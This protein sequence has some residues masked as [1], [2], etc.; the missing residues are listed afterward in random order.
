LPV[1][2][3]SWQVDPFWHNASQSRWWTHQ[4]WN[5]SRSRNVARNYRT[6]RKQ[7]GYT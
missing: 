2:I 5:G 3:R 6:S 1:V 4:T 7:P